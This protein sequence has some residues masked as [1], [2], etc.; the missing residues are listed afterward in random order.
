MPNRSTDELFQLVKSLD[1]GEKR[2]F[3]LYMKR[4][5]G[6]DDLKVIRLFDA[7]DKMS[8][9][10]EEALLKKNKSI[11]KQQLSN[12]KASLYKQVLAALRHSGDDDNIDMQLNEQMGYA[13]ILY[14]KGLY[15][16]ALKVLDKIKQTAKANYQLTFQMQVLFFE[17][18]IEALHITRS[19][20]NRAE[21][22]SHEV[23]EVNTHLSLLSKLSN[24]SLQ[25][26]SW[27]IKMGHARDEKD[28]LAVK[29]FFEVNLPAYNIHEM[30][31]YEKMY[32]YQ[33]Y[34]WYGFILQ[35]LLMYYRYTQK[36]VDLFEQEPF[37]K[38]VEAGQ[39]IKAMHN[40]LSAHFDLNNYEKFE[41]ALQQFERF[42]CSHSANMNPNA[43]IQTFVYLH[44]AK[45]NKH[46]LE[47]T[48]T[49][50][51][52]LV[53]VIEAKL[54]EYHLQLDRHRV[55]VFYYKIACL[56]FGSGD[57]EKAIDY[58][59]K[60]INWKVDLRTDLQ[61]YARLLHLIAHY[62]L[63]NY[64]L[65]EYLIKSVYR[66][67]AKM[68]N[69]SVVEEEIFKFLRK[70]F[71]L[72]RS[73]MIPA[74][75]TLKEKLQRYEGSALESRSFMYL[76]VIAWLECKIKHVPVQDVRRSRF[77]AGRKTKMHTEN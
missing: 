36:W 22:L 62:E 67:M 59:N 7:L 54:Q 63:G 45:I 2:L 25:L 12:I 52:E 42:A 34:C 4:G 56:Y 29:M 68:K 30:Q 58:L 18:K 3:K 43:R 51:L 33:S 11:S 70:S 66:F 50:G 5:S 26:Y 77:L 39:Y 16:Q 32:L 24:L 72:S 28:V 73:K 10:N 35:D 17:K 31:F 76:D 71:S 48:F 23:E 44:I 15:L 37:M 21:R 49:K 69:L 8:E 13:R 19:M 55:L 14:N 61:C 57:N 75:N 6:N 20:E 38:K 47:G 9:Y 27:Y 1:K 64:Q 46:F 40:V 60:I 65:L 53:P 41:E 74:F